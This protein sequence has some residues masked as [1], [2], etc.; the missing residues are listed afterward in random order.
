MAY[1][2]ESSYGLVD[3]GGETKLMQVADWLG[4]GVGVVEG[5]MGYLGVDWRREAVISKRIRER[6][7]P[8]RER[9][10]DCLEHIDKN[11]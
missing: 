5:I 9:R 8:E 4:C 1:T 3:E 2:L 10:N 7:R 6:E 11:S